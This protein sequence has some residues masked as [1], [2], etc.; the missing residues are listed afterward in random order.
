MIEKA[1]I[2]DAEAILSVINISN[3]EA[4]REVIPKEHFREPVLS[5]DELLRD[6]RRMTFYVYRSEGKIV[7]VAAL[8]IEDEHTGRIHLVYIL[9]EHQRTGIGTALVRYLEEKAREIGLRRLRL[10]TIK[11][12]YWA[13]NF[14]KELGYSLAEEI[15]RPWGLDVFMEKEC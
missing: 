9:P 2:E 6:F 1:R 4:Y 12:A 3:R 5:L 8:R 7:G 14:Y 15:E 11:K 13:V 10:L